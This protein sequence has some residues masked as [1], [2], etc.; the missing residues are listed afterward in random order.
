MIV[1]FYLR[2]KV[3]KRIRGRFSKKKNIREIGVN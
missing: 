1:F 2:G 3:G